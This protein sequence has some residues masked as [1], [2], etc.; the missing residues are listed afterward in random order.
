MNVLV[1]QTRRHAPAR[2]INRFHTGDIHIFK[3]RFHGDD[4][5]AG[6]KNVTHADVFRS[7]EIRIADEHGL[8]H[9]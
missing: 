7:I 1:D 5:A 3:M 8:G 9:W 4:L 2:C 6:D